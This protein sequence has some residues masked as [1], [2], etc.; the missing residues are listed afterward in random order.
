MSAGP[1]PTRVLIVDDDD[2]QRFVLR[3]LFRREGIT[4]VF[5][6]ADGEDALVVA[7][8]ERPD[9]V[10]LDLAMP[11]RRASTCCPSSA[12]GRPGADRRA[13]EPGAPPVGGRGPS[14]GARWGS[15]RRARRPTG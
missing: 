8:A 13:L 10:V 4:E 1:D 7:R 2:D 15:W 3:R 9:L 12:S 5:E 11:G 14:S 6:A